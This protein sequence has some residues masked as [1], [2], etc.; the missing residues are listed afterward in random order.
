MTFKPR[1]AIVTGSDSGIGRATA[2]ALA[3]PG[4][5]SGSPG[6]PTAGAEET[7]EEVRRT[8]GTPVV[9]RLDTTDLEVRWGD[10]PARRDW[11]GCDV[12]V[13]NSGT[14]DVALLV[15]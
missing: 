7:A 13:N 1:Y 3:R 12:F 15:D 5:T 8:A 14:G 11:A 2:V 6:T 4:S 9:A 10:R